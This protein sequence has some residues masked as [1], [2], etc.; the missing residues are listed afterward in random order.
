MKQ[1]SDSSTANPASQP[2]KQSKRGPTSKLARHTFLE[3]KEREK[4]ASFKK[5]YS[6]QKQ[7]NVVDVLL[8]DRVV[9]P[10]GG[11]CS[12]RGADRD[13]GDKFLRLRRQRPRQ[14]QR[15]PVR[16]TATAA[17]VFF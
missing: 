16:A 17:T 6:E 8:E 14:A 13:H 7:I 9:Q 2:P 12:R 5:K 11:G 3:K 10:D 15:R 4:R 1:A